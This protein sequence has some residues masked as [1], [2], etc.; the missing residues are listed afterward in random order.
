MKKISIIT[1]CYNENKNGLTECCEKIS[2]LFSEELKEYE[3]EHIICD[4]NSNKETISALRE[5]SS[6]TKILKLLLMQKTMVLQ[7]LF[8][9]V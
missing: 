2:K 9:M 8:S 5:I 4:N 7:N 1:P 6:K 3:Y